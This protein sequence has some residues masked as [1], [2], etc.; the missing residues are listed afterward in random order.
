MLWLPRLSFFCIFKSNQQ[1]PEEFAIDQ[2]L[3]DDQHHRAMDFATLAPDEMFINIPYLPVAFSA[4]P[5]KLHYPT[6]VQELALVAER[7]GW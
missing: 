4:L 1:E 7:E 2:S 6:G 3:T 5:W